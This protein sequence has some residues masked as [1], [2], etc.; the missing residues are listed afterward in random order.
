MYLIY[1]FSFCSTTMKAHTTSST[2]EHAIQGDPNLCSQ[3]IMIKSIISLEQALRGASIKPFT[4][5]G[6]ISLSP[7]AAAL[8]HW[9]FLKSG[10]YCQLSSPSQEIFLL[11]SLDPDQSN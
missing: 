5:A 1:E 2:L 9:L 11:Q 4:N 10:I 7:V 8:H 6:I 3:A